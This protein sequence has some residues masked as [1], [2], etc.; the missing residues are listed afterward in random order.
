[1]WKKIDQKKGELQTKEAYAKKNV[2]R[3][4][5]L[6]FCLS[7]LIIN[8]FGFFCL[9]SADSGGLSS[10]GGSFF[11]PICFHVSIIPSFITMTSKSK[12]KI[13]GEFSLVISIIYLIYFYGSLF[14]LF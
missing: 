12:L 11:A 6:F 14:S 3:K 13:I 1:M 4:S 10:I 8:L 7:S 9:L 2:N 5:I